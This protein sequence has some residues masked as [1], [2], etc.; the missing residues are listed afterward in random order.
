MNRIATNTFWGVCLFALLSSLPMGLLG[1]NTYQ[2][3]VNRG[4]VIYASGNDLVVKMEDG[5]VKRFVV[6]GDYKLTVD[7]KDVAVRDL[8]PGTMLT[9]T[10]T[11]TSEEQI[12]TNV[13]TV[14]A[15]VLEAKPPFLT[16]S[17]GDTIKHIKV[18]EGTKFTIN[19]KE[20]TLADLRAGMQVKGTV[21][22]AV[23]T[24]VVSRARTVTGQS[25]APKP[26]S[27]PTLIGVLLIEELDVT[28]K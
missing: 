10:I 2:F 12:V 16:I 22:T 21:V 8:K 6:P 4:T 18:P 7:G 3:D 27:T 15:K 19:G 13:R 25:P 20:M 26:V 23:P 28:E 1:Q 24:T 5:N 14:D 9:Q 17:S 11:T